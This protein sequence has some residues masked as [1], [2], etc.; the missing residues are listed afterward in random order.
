MSSDNPFEVSS[1]SYGDRSGADRDASAAEV[2]ART[3]EML[4]QTRPWVR[5]MGVLLWIGVVLLALGT[6]A[7]FFLAL[8]AGGGGEMLI[9]ALVYIFMTVIYG[10]LARSLTTYASRITALGISERIRDLED[11]LEAQMNFWRLI[12]IITLV[13]LIIYLVLI[14]LMVAG[15]A[16]LP[17]FM[18]P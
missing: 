12:G 1:Q 10:M 4:T 18:N 15:V 6:V 7:T 14:L 5:L 17:M 3:L 11:A 16:V 13:I 9:I 8:A 2:S